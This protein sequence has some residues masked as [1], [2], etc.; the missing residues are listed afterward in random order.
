[1]S[2]DAEQVLG[3]AVASTRWE[4]APPAV[5]DRV[6]DLVADTVAVAALGSAR[7][8]LRALVARLR[9][10]PGGSAAVPGSAR[11]WPASTAAF[12][13]GCA[14][15]ADQLQDGHRPARGHPASHV[16]TAV[17]AVAQEVGASGAEVLSAVLAG[18]EAGVRVGRAMGG[19]PAGVHDIGTW[20]ELAAAAGV[21]RLLAPGDAAAA[22]PRDRA[23]RRGRAADRRRDGLRRRVRRARVPRAVG[24]DRGRRRPRGRRRARPR[25]RRA[26]AAPRRRR[27]GRLASRGP[28][29]RGRRRRLG[30]LGGAR[31]VRQ[32]APHL[33][34]PARR[35]R[36]RRRPARRRAA[37]R[38]RGVGRGALHPLGRRL[39][40][41]GRRRA[42]GAVQ[43][44]DLGGGRAG[45][46]PAG[47]D[48]R[49]RRDR[50]ASRRRGPGR[51]GRGRGGRGRWTPRTRDGTAGPGGRDPARRRPWC[52]RP[53]TGRAATATGRSTGTACGTRPRGCCGT[54][55][56]TP[57]SRCWTPCTRWPTAARPSQL[58]D[59]LRSAARERP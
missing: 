18:Y 32:G 55:S 13:A 10:R 54:G 16:A 14:V 38:G 48:D 4:D 59:A 44:P 1:M 39:R 3:R 5:R 45:H 58:A 21:A 46:R 20:G 27:R 26:G 2:V 47:R 40:P 56:A 25:A 51:S 12:L 33:R 43:R 9:R 52:R 37:G 50:A 8:E 34:P 53:R 19:T 30:P 7:S 42:A 36:R 57:A 15:A 17:L 11:G 41:A 31:G 28:G 29:R 35:E 23:G 22:A 49:D 6:V 24:A